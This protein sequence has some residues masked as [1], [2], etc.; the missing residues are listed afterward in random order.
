MVKHRQL[1]TDLL[2][3]PENFLHVLPVLPPEGGNQAQAV[4]N[5]IKTL[6]IEL[7]TVP[8]ITQ[9]ECRILQLVESALH[10]LQNRAQHSRIKLDNILELMNRSAHQ[11]Q[12]LAPCIKRFI[13]IV[14][15]MV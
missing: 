8:V 13:G 9:L 12:R 4:L 3:I 10:L 7:H 2:Q 11:I 15:V 5:F 1:L 14:H 6:R